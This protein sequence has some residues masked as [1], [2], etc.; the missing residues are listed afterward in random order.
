[1]AYTDGATWV[2]SFYLLDLWIADYSLFLFCNTAL[3]RIAFW[4]KLE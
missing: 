4:L 2:K 1:V 3:K